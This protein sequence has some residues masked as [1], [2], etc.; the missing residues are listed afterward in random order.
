MQAAIE[1]RGLRKTYRQ[2]NE[3]DVVAVEGLD[4]ALGHPGSVHGFLGPNGSGK[5]TTIRCLLGLIQP[6][7]GSTVVLGEDSA[8]SFFRVASRVGAMVESPKLF[9]NFSAR[10]NLL[11]LARINSLPVSAVDHVLQVVGL[12]DRQKSTFGSYSLGMKQRL[13]IAAA[14]LKDPDL[15][16]LD[17][18]ANGLDPAGIAEMRTLIRS[19]AESGKAVVV[20]SHQLSEMELVCDNVTII[21]RGKLVVSGS[22]DEVRS[23]AGQDRVVATVHPQERTRGIDVLRA[24]NVVA[25]P[26]PPEGELV[27]TIDVDATAHVT[28]ILA[29]NGIYLSGLRTERSTLERAFLNLTGGPTT[30]TGPPAPPPPGAIPQNPGVAP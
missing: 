26:L 17:E 24:A 12:V 28:R 14:L 15:L 5:T 7:G 22:L 19:I 1:I 23:H 4:L 10:R 29:E 6:S 25:N 30:P 27:V 20:S 8:S 18:P 13:A 21:N 3:P 2:R 16:L 9:P 11:L